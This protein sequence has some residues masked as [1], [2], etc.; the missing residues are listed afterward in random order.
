ML[1]WG[2]KEQDNKSFKSLKK[3]LFIGGS[4]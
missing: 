2:A 4:V 3:N 1:G